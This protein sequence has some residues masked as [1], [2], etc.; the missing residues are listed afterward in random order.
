M[1]E[2]L[3]ADPIAAQHAPTLTAANID[4]RLASL[5]SNEEIR[6]LLPDAP[7]SERLAVLSVLHECSRMPPP[8]LPPEALGERSAA[9]FASGRTREHAMMVQEGTILLNGLLATISAAGLLSPQCTED[10]SEGLTGWTCTPLQGVD[11]IVWTI[12]LMFQ[13]LS[14]GLALSNVLVVA[15]LDD[16]EEYRNWILQ[17][18]MKHQSPM[19]FGLNSF[20][21]FMPAALAVRIWL[22][23][24]WPVALAVTVIIVASCFGIYNIL[25]NVIVNSALKQGLGLAALTMKEYGVLGPKFWGDVT[26]PL[27]FDKVIDGRAHATAKVAVRAPHVSS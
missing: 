12:C 3:E 7:V 19:A 8:Q 11:V 17:H 14:V 9:L 6:E 20:V 23:T 13:L 10:P 27:E 24:S 5:I 22:L 16:E 18:W 26:K 15:I 1:R 2:A 25:H 21:F 4:G